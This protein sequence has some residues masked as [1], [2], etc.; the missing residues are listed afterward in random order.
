MPSAAPPAAVLVAPGS[1]TI[2]DSAPA[3]DE[4]RPAA[5]T[6]NQAPWFDNRNVF[7]TPVLISEAVDA[8][9]ATR[10]RQVISNPQVPEPAHLLRVNY[11]NNEALI[12][13]RGSN[14]EWPSL[15]RA[16]FLIEAATRYINRNYYLVY[17][18][19]VM[20]GLSRSFLETPQRESVMHCKYWV[21]FA[22]G[23]LCATKT[24]VTQSYPGMSYF[25]EA[26]K[27]L[28]HLDERP[29]TDSIEALLLLVS[30]I[31]PPFSPLLTSSSS[32]YT[33]WRSI[34]DTAHTSFQEQRCVQPSSWAYISTYPNHNSPILP[35][36]IVARDSFG[37][38]TCSTECGGAN[39][40]LPAAIQD[41]EIEVDLPSIPSPT[42]S[43][44]VG[45]GSRDDFQ[46]AYHVANIELARHLNSVIRS[47]YRRTHHH[48]IHL[49]TRVQGSLQDLQSW[50][51]RLP[52]HLQID[53]SA[54]TGQD[55]N[56]VFLNLLFY[57]VRRVVIYIHSMCLFPFTR[58][59]QHAQYRVTFSDI[60]SVLLLQPALSYSI[61]CE[62]KSQQHDPLRH[63][64]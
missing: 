20:E 39:L 59:P 33:H 5:I 43:F 6:F 14:I 62:C 55:L 44:Q 34:D 1:A 64:H 37:R 11:A 51:D 30:S 31:A 12:A 19:S 50:V 35:H 8:A 63:P 46:F 28:G 9:F 49:A 4:Q 17:R 21:L 61:H 56:A 41:D 48:D 57:Q 25:A 60:C 23:E 3:D 18:K 52:P 26:S 32:R 27:M 40:G 10:F 38:H 42:G 7:Q 22:I 47:V 2:S 13:L 24:S 36:E 45:D 58:S 16:G 53:P 15:A 54:E 29:G